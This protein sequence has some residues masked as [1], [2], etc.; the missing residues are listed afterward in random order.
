LGPS[1]FANHEPFDTYRNRRT[2]REDWVGLHRTDAAESQAQAWRAMSDIKTPDGKSIVEVAFEAESLKKD[3]DAL[4][5]LT[6]Q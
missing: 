1:A 2:R 4:L 6:L 5:T 3:L